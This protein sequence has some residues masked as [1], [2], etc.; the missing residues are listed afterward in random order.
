MKIARNKIFLSP[1]AA[2][3]FENKFLNLLEI[4]KTGLAHQVQST[5]Q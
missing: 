5:I 2:Y 3:N 4:S 1:G